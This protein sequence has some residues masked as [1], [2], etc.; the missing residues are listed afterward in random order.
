MAMDDSTDAADRLTNLPDE[1][2]HRIISF[3]PTRDAV[4]TCILSSS[5]R[6]FWEYANRVDFNT[7]DFASKNGFASFVDSRM[8]RYESK[9]LSIDSFWIRSCR[10]HDFLDDK[11][12]N[13]WVRSAVR[14]KARVI[15]IRY[16]RQLELLKL[17]CD[18]FGSRCLKEIYLIRV[19]ISDAMLLNLS[20][21]CPSL[22][23]LEL[24]GCLFGKAQLS[25]A[26][27]KFLSIDARVIDGDQ[28]H[29][30]DT[31]TL[32]MLRATE[33]GARCTPSLGKMQAL[34][35]TTIYLDDYTFSD[36]SDRWDM[37]S[38][39]SQAPELRLLSSTGNIVEEVL[40]HSFRF[41]KWV[42]LRNL[43]RVTVSDWCYIS[44]CNLLAQLLAL[45][46]CLKKLTLK[47]NKRSQIV[48]NSQVSPFECPSLRHLEIEGWETDN[49]INCVV[50]ILRQNV[51]SLETVHIKLLRLVPHDTE[52]FWQ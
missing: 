17:D 40:T 42:F 39:I 4:R 45:S 19:S 6:N 2:I 21:G 32:L 11:R 38:L 41:P 23:T 29:F 8:A 36:V 22:E 35:K 48:F 37:F 14:S 28:D 52:G 10:S 24:K 26:S 18:T 13:I 44:D 31:F 51:P 3:L 46:P 20:S 25:S 34:F 27:L 7:A 50:Q 16:Y 1:L 9:G 12:T 33:G 47:F 5:W 43:V 15:G 30:L 49:R